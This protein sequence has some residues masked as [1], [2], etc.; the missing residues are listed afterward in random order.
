MQKLERKCRLGRLSRSAL[1]PNGNLA[2]ALVDLDSQTFNSVGLRPQ[3][4]LQLTADVSR[5][6]LS[7]RI[8]YREQP[9]VAAGK[10]PAQFAKRGVHGVAVILDAQPRVLCR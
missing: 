7:R 8:G 2:I 9:A 10:D 5:Q 6:H 4:R 1:L 3:R